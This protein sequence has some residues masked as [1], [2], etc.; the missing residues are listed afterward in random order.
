MSVR[1]N[2]LAT[3]RFEP[4]TRTPRWELG[5]WS[6]A[7]HRW[8]EEGL[9]GKEKEIRA[10]ESDASW[11]SGGGIAVPHS[12]EVLRDHDVADYFGMDRGT[13]AV[14]VNY[15]NCPLFETV[16]LEE[17][18]EFLIR[19][20]GWGI[21]SKVLKPERGMPFWIDYPVHNRQEWERFKAERYQPNLSERV[22]DNWDA[23]LEDYKTRDYPLCVG[24][25]ATGYFGTVRQILGAE[26]TLMTFYDDPAW[27]H[28]MMDHLADFYVSLYDQILSTVKVDY[29]A[30]WEDMCYVAG[31]LISPRTF[32][33]FML[34]PYKKLSGLLRD[35]G[36][37]IFV[38]DTDGDAWKL[39]DLFIEG[40]ITGMYPFE[41][42][43][44]MDVRRVR[45]RYPRLA[46]QGGIDKKALSAG[47]GAIDRELEAKVPVAVEGGYIPHVDHA[48]PS[49]I[50]WE[51]FSYY[52][53]K[54]DA[55][56]DEIDAKRWQE[57]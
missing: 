35:H 29:A 54:L 4:C 6:G 51:N 21:V 50:S 48:S 5:F 20:D 26:R 7:I 56:L 57:R 16:V 30:H 27:M 10:Q 23:L 49:D 8:Y 2:F 14:E 22:P 12:S 43:S 55:M 46:L 47:K 24:L 17:T 28:D 44:N 34:E 52:R 39:L 37:D 31:P 33:E 45:K 42:Q 36:I 15:N 19:R 25:G 41:V 13:V 32:G 9:P 38:V 18:D 1:E 53:H 40:G 3:M 11:V